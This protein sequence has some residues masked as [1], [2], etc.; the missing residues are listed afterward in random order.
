MHFENDG[1]RRMNNEEQDASLSYEALRDNSRL[2]NSRLW[3]A[4]NFSERPRALK[5]K[6]RMNHFK[7]K[8]SGQNW[9]Q[10]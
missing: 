6:V 8:D 7:E 5:F 4:M 1:L 3:E 2:M 9:L 10:L